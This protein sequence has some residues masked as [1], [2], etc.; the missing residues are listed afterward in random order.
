MKYHV[1]QKGKE[2]RKVC[3][4]DCMGEGDRKAHEN[5]WDF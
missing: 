4:T 3:K 2:L 5:K 1:W